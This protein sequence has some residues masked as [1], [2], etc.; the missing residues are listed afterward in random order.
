MQLQDFDIELDIQDEGFPLATCHL[1]QDQLE[2]LG[3]HEAVRHGRRLLELRV[4]AE[5]EE[6][7]RSYARQRVAMELHLLTAV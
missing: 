5:N 2:Y 4:R 1:V 3:A 6:A 7:A